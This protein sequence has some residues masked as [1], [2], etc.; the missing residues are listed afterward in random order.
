MA[1]SVVAIMAYV[2]T[3]V[4]TRILT[5]LKMEVTGVTL[6]STDQAAAIEEDAQ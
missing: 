2:G 4:V 5:V 3:A 1:T 6:T